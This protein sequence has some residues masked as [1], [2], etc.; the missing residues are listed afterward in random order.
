MLYTIRPH[1]HSH[2]PSMILASSHKL[3]VFDRFVPDNNE[4][5]PCSLKPLDHVFCTTYRW[6]RNICSLMNPSTEQSV[7]MSELSQAV[8]LQCAGDMH[9][10]QRSFPLLV[11]HLTPGSPI[12]AHPQRNALLPVPTRVPWWFDYLACSRAPSFVLLW[13]MNARHCRRAM[14]IVLWKDD[15]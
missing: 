5:V 14:S 4:F 8:H 6:R 7:C 13:N 9:Y 10:S 1:L 12:L 2:I 11:Y 15:L 3:L